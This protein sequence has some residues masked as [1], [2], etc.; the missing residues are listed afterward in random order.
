MDLTLDRAHD[1]V[2]ETVKRRRLQHL[3][4]QQARKGG[5]TPPEVLMEIEDLRHDLAAQ[6][7]RIK[8]PKA[9]D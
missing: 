6:T 1:D 3:E 9:G 7:A 4:E 5:N 8:K 2:P